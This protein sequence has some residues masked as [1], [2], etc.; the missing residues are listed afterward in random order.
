MMGSQRHRRDRDCVGCLHRKAAKTAACAPGST[1]GEEETTAVYATI[2][3][4]LRSGSTVVPS[5]I[6]DASLLSRELLAQKESR[7]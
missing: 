3:M 7:I 2:L 5:A 6:G 4:S 1:E